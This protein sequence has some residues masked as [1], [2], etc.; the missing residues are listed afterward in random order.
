MQR[1]DIFPVPHWKARWGKECVSLV[2][3]TIL[4]ARPPKYERIVELDRKLQSMALPAYAT[5]PPPQDAS[6]SVLMQHFMPQNY[7][8]LSEYFS[9]TICHQDRL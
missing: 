2:V 4:T 1:T 7:R 8:D 6:L 3:Q 9:H 5:V